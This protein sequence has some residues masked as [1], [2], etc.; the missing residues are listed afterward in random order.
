MSKNNNKDT[1]QCTLHGISCFYS[2]LDFDYKITAPNGKVY[3]LGLDSLLYEIFSKWDKEELKIQQ[4]TGIKDSGGKKI[5]FGDKLR[6]ADKW[7]WYRVEWA[8]KLIGKSGE[9]LKKLQAE[10]D[11]LPYEERLIENAEDYEWLLSSEIQSY[12]ELCNG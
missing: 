5:Y 3:F 8:W 10:Y 7:E 4:Y 2:G 6:F 11:A 1:E 12:W 9:E